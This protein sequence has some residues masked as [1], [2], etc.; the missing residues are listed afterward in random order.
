MKES[1]NNIHSLQTTI[2]NNDSLESR[3]QFLQLGEKDRQAISRIRKYIT[4]ELSPSLDYFYD[5]VRNTETTKAFF[6]NEDAIRQAKKAQEAHW[7]SISSATFDE[8]YAARVR[9]VGA[10][11]ASIG[12]DPRWYIDGYAIIL[13]QLISRII[14]AISPK[15]PLIPSKLSSSRVI[16]SLTSLCKAVMLDMDLTISVYLD[17]QKKATA[18]SQEKMSQLDDAIQKER[19]FV[20]NSFGKMLSTIA[21]QNLSHQMHGDF[22][23]A[24]VPMLDN[25]NQAITS[26]RTT[27]RSVSQATN[28]IDNT[29]DEISSATQDLAQRTEQQAASVEKTAAA[30]EEITAAVSS[31]EARVT[32][33][34]KFV[35]ECQA[36]TEQFGTMIRRAA[37]AMNE[38]ERSAEAVNK[39]TNVISNIATQT[40][41]LALNTGVEAAHAGEAG[42]GFRVLAQEIRKLA[43]RVGDA[44]DEVKELIS[45][46]QSHVDAGS[47]IMKDASEAIDTIISSVANISTH[48]KAISRA[49]SEQASALRDVNNAV[50]TI[51]R[52]TRENAAMVEETSAATSNMAKLTRQLKN[53][54]RKF[55][56][57]E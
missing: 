25:L 34:N 53:L 3:L 23:T 8:H 24:Y 12:L 35:D 26:L 37:I 28:S 29:A 49:T 56:L 13:S 15:T 46:S 20:T 32:E 4:K 54:L 57:D 19:H 21:S 38:I 47:T 42:S 1:S 55:K 40:N 39:I 45:T 11:H 51:D 18:Q 6:T 33:A 5:I 9:Q 22:P 48:L 41:L 10:A 50:V 14:K 36:I 43:N 2:H 27:L 44:S 31:T 30:V 52:G 16:H 17:E 7:Q